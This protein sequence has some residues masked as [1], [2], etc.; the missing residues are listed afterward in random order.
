[1]TEMCGCARQRLGTRKEKIV[2]SWESMT[3]AEFEGLTVTA[4]LR[5]E[6]IIVIQRSKKE[7]GAR[8]ERME[9]ENGCEGGKRWNLLG[10][11]CVCGREGA[12]GTI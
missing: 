1:M 9:K 5:L 4:W 2:S 3:T 7:R 11:S 12:M 8:K 6:L 10:L